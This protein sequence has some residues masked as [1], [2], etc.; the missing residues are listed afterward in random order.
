M[1]QMFNCL[2]YKASWDLKVTN[3]VEHIGCLTL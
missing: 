2:L 3:L 1:T